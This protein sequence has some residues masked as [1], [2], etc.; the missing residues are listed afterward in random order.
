MREKEH[1]NSNSKKNTVLDLSPDEAREGAHIAA[2]NARGLLEFAVTGAKCR[3][4]GPAI[5]LC[6]LA[7]EEAAKALALFSSAVS[8]E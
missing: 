6:V 1:R 4:F 3:N 5:A 8:P 2:R 7:S